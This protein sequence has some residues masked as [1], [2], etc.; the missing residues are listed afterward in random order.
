MTDRM[1]YILGN[2]KMNLDIETAMSVAADVAD[3]ANDA[4]D[5]VGVGVAIPYPWIPL[6]AGEHAESNLLIGAQDVS[7]EE[8]GAFTGDVS[9]GML[10]PWCTFVIIGHSERRSI[11]GESNALVRAK[12]A[13]ALAHGMAPVLCVG[14][15]QAQRDAGLTMDVVSDQ[16]R[17]ASTH[18]GGVE[19]RSLLVA[20]EPVWAI[21]TGLT[22]EPTDAQAV[23]AH[24][25]QVLGTVDIE[26]AAS[27]PI[28]YG[29]SV[30]G[31]NADAYF[32]CPDVDGALVG[33]ASLS[34]DAF[35]PIVRA[36][37]G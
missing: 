20:Y 35:L 17:S 27:V 16:V 28:L 24:I 33:G 12:L 14:E 31:D 19:L 8:S 30:N 10:A 26:A 18:L 15:T 37:L 34:A 9:A 2:W 4:A 21:G 29:G 25:R 7:P 5:D 22:A 11:H 1:P 32:A 13:A 23:A 36:A 3:I 6:I